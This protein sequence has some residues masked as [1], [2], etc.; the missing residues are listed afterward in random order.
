MPSE[1]YS[2]N[3]TDYQFRLLAVLCHLSG[4]RG[5]LRIAAGELCVLTGNVHVKTVRRGLKALEEAGFIS[6]K[7]VKKGGGLQ[8]PSLIKIGNSNVHPAGDANVH[9]TGGKVTNSR[10]SHIAN[11]PL[12]PNSQSS[13]KL[14]D[15]ESEIQLKEIQVPMRKY[16]D[17]GDNLAGFGLVEPKDAPQPKIRKSDPKTR[18]RRPEHEWTAMDVAAEFSYQVGRKYPLLPGTVSVKSLSGALAKFR[19][20]YETT[21]LIELELLRLF[22]ADENNFKNIGDEAPFLYKMFLASFGKKMNQAR[23]NLG[24]NKITA[25]LD[26]SPTSARLSASDGRTF[27][28][29]I[30]GRAQLER[31]EKRLSDKR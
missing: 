7:V 6:R 26:T 4:S 1:A 3:L 17:D 18:G 16:D 29:S 13:Y 2:A 25:K 28:N 14:K 19:K 31:H 8:G 9:P 24:L 30:S 10:N 23:E 22:M 15:F 20:Q 21:A 5:S 27:Q 12:V 11:K